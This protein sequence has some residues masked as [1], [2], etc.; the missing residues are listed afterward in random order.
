MNNV[1]Y[2]VSFTDFEYGEIVTCIFSYHAGGNG[3]Y[4]ATINRNMKSGSVWRYE[5]GWQHLFGYKGS[6]ERDMDIN[7]LMNDTDEI[8]FALQLVGGL[9]DE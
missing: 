3:L 8:H 7:V 1:D 5:R 2:K 6:F 4:K 9:R